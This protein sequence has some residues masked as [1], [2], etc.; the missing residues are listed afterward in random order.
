MTKTFAEPPRTIPLNAIDRSYL[1]PETGNIKGPYFPMSPL[2][3]ITL[4]RTLDPEM[5]VEALRRLDSHIPQLRLAYTLDLQHSRWQRVPDQQLVSYFSTLVTPST[6]PEA[7][8]ETVLSETICANIEPFQQP[9][10]IILHR[11]H[12]IIRINHSFADGMLGAGILKAVLAA[13]AGPEQLG[14]LPKFERYHGLALWRLIAQNPK[15][16]AQVSKGWFQSLRSYYPT[17]E[18]DLLP[19]WHKPD[20]KPVMCGSP[21][22]VRLFMIDAEAI[23]Q[24]KQLKASLSQ[25]G[26]VSMNTLLQVLLAHRLHALGY[27]G[28]QVTYSIPVDLHRYLENAVEYYPGNLSSQIRVKVTEHPLT[29]IAAHC[30]TVEAQVQAQL[31]NA[32][33]LVNLPYEWLMR[34]AG[35]RTY[36]RLNR[37][38]LLAS[39]HT[40]PRLFVLSNLGNLTRAFRDFD[41]LIDFEAGLYSIGPLMGGPPLISTFNIVGKR[42]HVA[43]TYDPQIFSQDQIDQ[44]F[45]LFQPNWLETLLKKPE[46]IF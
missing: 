17:T 37:E 21:M 18:R 44:I 2:G 3:V 22:V 45:A 38:W 43:V 23:T 41:D 35:R 30:H 42:G 25:D 6:D 26:A 29:N 12:F 19:Q 27:L 14:T 11:N 13:L 9:L 46:E 31:E 16:I 10:S 15:R 34:L 1:I 20:R 28:Q 32:A 24:L 39:I 7:S 36:N 33:P 8:L 4:Q 5:V 40:D